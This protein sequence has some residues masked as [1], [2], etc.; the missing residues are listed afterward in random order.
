MKLSHYL[1]ITV[2]VA[3]LVFGISPNVVA[4]GKPGGGGG[5]PPPDPPPPANYEITFTESLSFGPLSVMN[6]DGSNKAVILQPQDQIREASGSPVPIRYYFG[7]G[8]TEAVS[9]P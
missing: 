9:I 5:K 2:L 7:R 6:A 1:L 8:R 3:A 4:K